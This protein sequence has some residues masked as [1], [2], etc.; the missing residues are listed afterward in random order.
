MSTAS[1]EETTEEAGPVLVDL[2]TMD[3][4]GL[5]ELSKRWHVSKQRVSEITEARC[6]HWKKL[7][8]GRIWLLRDVE[9]FEKK[10]R[11]Q[12]GIH[13]TPRKRREDAYPEEEAE[14]KKPRRK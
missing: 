11:R 4:L 12:T 8:C 10:W 13:V 7:D 5:S 3:V 14:L 6:P 9:E 1:L 2:A